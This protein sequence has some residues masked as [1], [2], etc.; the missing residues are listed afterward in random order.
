MPQIMGGET[1]VPRDQ[2]IT[3]IC[4]SGRRSTQVLYKL[5]QEG[6]DNLS[7]LEGG[8]LAW[9]ASGLPAVID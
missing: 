6:Y 3:L 4:R 7:N 9:E 5:Q 8:M 1:A 2:N